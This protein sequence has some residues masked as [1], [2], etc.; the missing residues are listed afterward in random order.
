MTP[1]TRLAVGLSGWVIVFC[2]FVLGCSTFIGCS[3][4]QDDVEADPDAPACGEATA[5]GCHP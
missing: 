5:S 4:V 2:A 1:A 3:A